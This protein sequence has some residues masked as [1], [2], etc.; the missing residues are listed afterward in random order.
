M[1]E[2]FKNFTVLIAK[3][4]RSIKKIKTEEMKEF[5]LKSPHVSC[6][7]YLFQESSL[8]AK[9]LENI[10]QEDKASLSRSLEHLENCG[11][12]KYNSDLKKKYKTSLQLT[13]KGK[14]IATIITK[15]IDNNLNLASNGL[16]EEK[17]KI[18][19]ESLNLISKNLDNICNKYGE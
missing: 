17:R 15:K 3:I 4:N 2:R 12:I 18:L 13:Q 8:T 5:N 6:L 14:E 10:C 11:Y 9:E 19:Y 7:Y 16:N 1:Q